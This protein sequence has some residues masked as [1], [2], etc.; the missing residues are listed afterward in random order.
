MS[1]LQAVQ[2][3]LRAARAGKRDLR[4]QFAALCWRARRGRV[5]VL[6]VTARR[7]GRWIPPKGWPMRGL[8]PADAAAREAWEEAGAEGRTTDACLGVYTYYKKRLRL[9]CAVAVYPL[10]VRRLA[11]DWPERSERR[12]RWMSRAKAASQ[13][14]EPELARILTS[15]DPGRR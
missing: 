6:L 9:P 14:S 2:I 5:E 11:R 10:E 13:V 12:R 7:S 8:T 1:Y 3:P 4:T 15:F